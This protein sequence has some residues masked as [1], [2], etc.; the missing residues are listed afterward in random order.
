M[1]RVQQECESGFAEEE[2]FPFE[3]LCPATT[4]QR[5][6]LSK[7]PLLFRA[8]RYPEN[9]PSNL[10]YWGIECGPGW[11]LLLDRAADEIERELERLVGAVNKV[12]NIS[13]FD[14]KLRDIC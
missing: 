4:A 1:K 7:Y 11:Y 9:Y 14:Q 8:A 5:R 10:G 2:P 13:W 6:L 3:R 12:Q